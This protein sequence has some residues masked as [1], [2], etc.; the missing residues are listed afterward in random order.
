LH[1]GKALEAQERVSQI[2]L[3]CIGQGN[4]V[5]LVEPGGG[6][7]REGISLLNFQSDGTARRVNEGVLADMGK[8]QAV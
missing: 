6:H 3:V 2:T 4:E 5:A 8:A 7:G 1:N